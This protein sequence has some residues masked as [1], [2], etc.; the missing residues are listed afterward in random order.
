MWLP[1]LYTFRMEL[2]IFFSTR[3]QRVVREWVERQLL[4]QN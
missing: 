2:R 4:D 3:R 1:K